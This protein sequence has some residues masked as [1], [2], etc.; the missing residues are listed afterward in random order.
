VL[1]PLAVVAAQA[2]TA[3]SGS[4]K[5]NSKGPKK[6]KSER[7]LAAAIAQENKGKAWTDEEHERFLDAL[8]TY[9]SGPWKA[10]ADFVG[11]KNSRQ[12]M[13]HAQKYRQKHERRERGLR[14]RSKQRKAAR[15]M[16][17]SSR[18]TAKTRSQTSVKRVSNDKEDTEEELMI[19][20][21][22]QQNAASP[23]SDSPRSGEESAAAMGVTYLEPM[24]VDSLMANSD[25]ESDNDNEE[26]D[27]ASSWDQLKISSISEMFQDF[28]PMNFLPTMWS[29]NS[30]GDIEALAAVHPG[31]S[32]ELFSDS[33]A[34]STLVG[35]INTNLLSLWG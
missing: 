2:S 28:E 23:S 17:S 31:A 34:G 7:A 15:A 13:T 12:T 5:R 6:S 27:G 16:V 29:T 21:T 35:A 9:P 19:P 33:T 26:D 18:S 20:S 22:P 3:K 32:N 30:L 8:K 4:S 11:T 14:N 24:T 10:I 1:P 25:D